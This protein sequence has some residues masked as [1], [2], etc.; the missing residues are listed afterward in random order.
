[1]RDPGD[2]HA[3]EGVARRD[4]GLAA[5]LADRLRADSL[6]TPAR[7]LRTAVAP[8]G[9]CPT[10]SL[11]LARRPEH[12]CRLDR[13]A[14]VPTRRPVRGGTPLRARRTAALRHRA[15]EGDGSERHSG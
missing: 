3:V 5:A 7:A 8:D 11:R 1:M 9:P 6:A 10:R 4:G 13:R 15:V 2:R 12:D 14:D